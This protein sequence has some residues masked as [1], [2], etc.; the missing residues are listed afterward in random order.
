MSAR[1]TD[2]S[3]TAVFTGT[4]DPLTLGHLDVIRRGRQLFDHLVVAIGINPNKA[5]LFNVQERVALARKV[6]EPFDN[7]TVESFEGLTVQFVRRIGARVI[8]RGLRTLSDMEYE[9]GM[10]LT[11]Q[12][13][14]PTLETVFLM[15]DGEYSH[16]SST[17]I[18]QIARFGGAESLE[19]FVP[20]TL[21]G[22]IMAK[23][24]E[25]PTG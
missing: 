17:L 18:K 22:P 21:I 12:R 16:V 10:T 6:V 11:N 20:E 24:R 14:D 1:P 5:A 25:D 23:M 15:A 7:V 13:L 4:F 19:R 2:P 9:F 3:H 8:L